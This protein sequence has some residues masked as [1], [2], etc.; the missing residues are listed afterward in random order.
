M[1]EP[2][3][4]GTAFIMVTLLLDTLGVGLIIPV[5]PKLVGSFL[6]DDLAAASRWFGILFALYSVMQFVFAPILGGLSDRFGRR[7]VILPSLLGAAASY[8]FSALAPQLWWLFVGRTIAGIT[9]ASFSAAT[10]YIAD[11]SPPEKRA[12]NFGL[13]GAAFGLGFVVGPSSGVPSAA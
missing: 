13:V 4:A 7:T 8:L 11:V 5:G 3:R 1:R 9:G 2:S 12:Q 6:H 10:A